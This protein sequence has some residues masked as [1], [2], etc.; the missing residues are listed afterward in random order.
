MMIIRTTTMMIMMLILIIM[1]IIVLLIV[2]IMM[3]MII[4]LIL[5]MVI[6]MIIMLTCWPGS[7]LF[8]SSLNADA[9][10]H[11]QAKALRRRAALVAPRAPRHGAA[12]ARPSGGPTSKQRCNPKT[13]PRR[14]ATRCQKPRSLGEA[15]L[16]HPREKRHGTTRALP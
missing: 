8:V 9:G 5:M 15:A 7:W 4:M 6:I 10:R 2:M 13:R 1:M 11:A 16:S 12:R 3:V 14:S